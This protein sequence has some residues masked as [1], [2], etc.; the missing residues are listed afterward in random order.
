[1]AQKTAWNATVLTETDI[2]LYLAGEGGA[3]TTWS[4]VVVQGATP[5][6]T[7]NRAKYARYGRTIIGDAF[8]TCTSGGTGAT[9]ITISTPTTM[10]SSS[11]NTIIGSGWVFDASS[12]FLYYGDLMLASTTT[13]NFLIRTNGAG[14]TYIGST[15]FTAALAASDVIS[16]QF[17][18]ESAT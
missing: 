5:G 14:P 11:A 18:Y 9:T 15:S 6:L 8:V 2:N 1:M 4:P 13:A 17:K 12:G 3:W 7:V 10:A 16:V